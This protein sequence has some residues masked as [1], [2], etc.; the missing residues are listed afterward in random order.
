[1]NMEIL[2]TFKYL[3]ST[4][5]KGFLNDLSLIQ[6]IQMYNTSDSMWSLSFPHI[7]IIKTRIANFNQSYYDIFLNLKYSFSRPVK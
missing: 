6:I 7:E 1:M 4:V 2:N 3:N 5:T